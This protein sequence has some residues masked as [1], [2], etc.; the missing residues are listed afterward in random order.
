MFRT[1]RKEICPFDNRKELTFKY[2]I[3]SS[4]EKE[5][6]KGK[7][8]AHMAEHVTLDKVPLHA[9]GLVDS[10]R[11]VGSI[12]GKFQSGNLVGGVTL[13]FLDGTAMA[14]ATRGGALHGLV[15][16]LDRPH[17]NSKIRR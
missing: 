10:L 13:Q 15:R 4:G 9:L 8:E 12:S 7:Y 2:M 16:H 14:G 11:V 1:F 5:G 6:S 17:R 3:R